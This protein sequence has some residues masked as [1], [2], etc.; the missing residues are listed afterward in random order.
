LA[1]D[2][3]K[4]HGVPRWYDDARKLI[5]DPRVDA[6]YVATPPGSHMEYA[7]QAAAA[8]K[9]AYVEK[10]MAR[11][12]AECGRMIDAFSAAGLPLFVA[13]YRRCLPKFVKAKEIIDAGRLGKVT[14]VC[15]RLAMPPPGANDRT[16][17]GW[18]L[19]AEQSGGGLFMDV[20]CHTLDILD[21]LMGPLSDVRGSAANLAGV[22]NVEDAVAMSFRLPEG[23]LGTGQWNF[24]SAVNEDLIQITGEQGRLTLSTFGAEPMRLVRQEGQ[25]ESFDLPNP[26]HVQQ[27][28]IQTIV[29]ELRGRGR[30]PSHGESAARTAKVMDIVLA[31]Y[32]GGRD[33]AYWERP[34]TWPGRLND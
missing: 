34:G 24:A 6:V 8:G 7:L 5:E 3:A 20:G 11:N 33:D 19:N 16:R 10:P 21:Y 26:P 27:P 2:C 14:G 22:G 15:C 28:L 4:R 25:E 31:D 32:Y 9:P 30:C 1:R 17:A 29:D 12:H 13:Y 18:H 23:A